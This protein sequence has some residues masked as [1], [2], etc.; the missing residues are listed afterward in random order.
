MF[1][2]ASVVMLS[3]K[4]RVRYVH[5]TKLFLTL[6]YSLYHYLLLYL[7]CSRHLRYWRCYNVLSDIRQ[8]RKIVGC[9]NI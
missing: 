1:A 9:L 8:V 7:K 5:R 6:P 3:L 4:K 2:I